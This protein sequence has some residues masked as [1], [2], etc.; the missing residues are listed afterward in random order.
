MGIKNSTAVDHIVNYSDLYR[1]YKDQVFKEKYLYEIKMQLPVSKELSEI[2]TDLKQLRKLMTE[3][4][5]KT[6]YEQIV[7][8]KKKKV[9]SEPTIVCVDKFVDP[10]F[11]REGRAYLQ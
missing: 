2:K 6:S 5:Q 1:K 8:D 10:P 11:S 9:D 3:R 4:E 7:N